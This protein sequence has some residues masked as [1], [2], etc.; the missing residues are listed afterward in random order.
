MTTSSIMPVI[1]QVE[2]EMHPAS[3][4]HLHQA[5]VDAHDANEAF[6]RNAEPDVRAM[7]T[8]FR[9]LHDRH[10]RELVT[11]MAGHGHHP[12]EGGGFASLMHKGV[13]RLRDMFGDSDDRVVERMI[14]GEREVVGAY[15]HALM[16]GGPDDIVGLLQRQLEELERLIERHD[17]GARSV[18]AHP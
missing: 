4:A 11:A 13:A 3:L 5:I 8:A 9:D 18:G 6:A 10:D 1:Q 15:N 12:D 2:G 7:L 14:D 16:H 17:P